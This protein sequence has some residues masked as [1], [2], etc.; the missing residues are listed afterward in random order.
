VEQATHRWAVAHQ[1][2]L[3]LLPC[4]DPGVLLDIDLPEHLPMPAR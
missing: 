3:L 4:D 2:S 1:S